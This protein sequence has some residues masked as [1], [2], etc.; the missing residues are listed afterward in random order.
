M[1]KN[2]NEFTAD[3]DFKK[4]P[5]AVGY[6]ALVIPEIMSS[7]MM[8]TWVP[9]LKSGMILRSMEAELKVRPNMTPEEFQRELEKKSDSADNALGQAIYDNIHIKKVY[10]DALFLALRSFGWTGG[11]VQKI[12]KGIGEIPLSAKRL[13]KGQGITN[14]TAWL[15]ALPATLAM[16]GALYQKGMTGNW[17][18]DMQDYFFPKDGT[19]NDD[20]TEHRVVLPSYMKDLFAYGK[21]PKQTVINKLSPAVSDLATIWQNKDFY[22]EQVWNPDDP[23][24]QKGIDILNYEAKSSAPFSFQTRPGQELSDAQAAQ[25]K[26]GI[27]PAPK[28]EERDDLQNS[29]MEAYGKSLE[30]KPAVSHD[31]MAERR[32]RTELRKFINTGGKWEHADPD[33]KEAAKIT[34]QGQ[35]EFIKEAKMDTYERYFKHISDP[36]DK[37]RIY[38]DMDIPDQKKYFEYMPKE[39]KENHKDPR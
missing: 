39:Y 21:H 13:V 18:D 35:A 12:G 8:N 9:A 15:V 2:W 5:K 24:L 22:G 29:I 23:I 3:N 19:Y 25:Q 6:A 31:A 28:E 7:H 17:P 33:L 4:L 32:A 20:G 34:E 36:E 38:E 14:N 30:G 37:I 11:T 10:K 27:V 16:M 1:K 26:I